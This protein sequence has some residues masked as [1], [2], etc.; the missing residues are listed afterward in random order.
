M[1]VDE[2]KTGGNDGFK[3][4][5]GAKVAFMP[6]QQAKVDELINDAYKRAYAKALKSRPVS[7]EVE[8]LKSENE[9]LRNERKMAS[10]YRAVSKFNVVDAEE[11]AKLVSD[12]IRLDDAGIPYATSGGA[13]SQRQK[14]S[15][16]DYIAS[17][18]SNR[19][20]HLRTGGVRGAGSQGAKFGHN[21]FRH[22]PE[23]PEAWRKM[24]RED[25][26]RRLEGGITVNGSAGQVYRFKDIKNPFIEAR[27][28]RFKPGGNTG[29]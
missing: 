12:D 25:L 20:H 28:R 13:Q 4:A 26:D 5:D 1:Q 8:S 17:W 9:A 21:G 3:E 22:N 7:D 27:K 15:V 14:V 19:Q 18:L 16:E 6:E 29:K 23:D 10:I 2:L 11:V 24:P